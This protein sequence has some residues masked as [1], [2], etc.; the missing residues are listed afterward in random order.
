M[1]FCT[2]RRST[3]SLAL[4]SALGLA[5]CADNAAE[6]DWTGGEGA[7]ILSEPLGTVSFSGGNRL[8][9]EVGFGS[10]ATHRDGD[11]A[12]VFYTVTD[13]GPNVKCSDS[14]DIVGVADFCGAGNGGDKIFPLPDYAPRI[15]KIKLSDDFKPEI[16]ETIELKDADGQP[17]TGLTNPL[18]A[19]DTEKAF[20]PDGAQITFDP[21]GLDTESIAALADGSFWLSDEYGPSLVHVAADGR[22]LQ[23]VVPAS[24]AADL[25]GAGYPVSGALPD[26]LK[27]RK[28]NRGIESVAI[29]PDEN[30]LYFILQ[31][32]LAHPDVAAYAGSRQVRL[33]KYALQADG[34]LGDAL[35]EYVYSLDTPQTFAD[36][37]N[38]TGDL[39]N[40]TLRKQKDVKLSEMVAV[41]TD[42]LIVLERISKVTKL[43]RV[44]LAT[45]DNILHTA[46]SSG[47]VSN[48]ESTS[49][50]TLELLFDPTSAGARPLVKSLAF[51]SLTDLPDGIRL[52]SKVEGIARLDDDYVLLINDNDFGIEGN[53]SVATVLEIGKRLTGDAT[54]SQR[55]QL[56]QRGSY[57]SGI[58][59]QSAAEISAYAEA[60]QEVLVTNAAT[61]RIDIL[62]ASDPAALSKVAELD[63]AT[64]INDPLLG[65][66]NSVAVHG[67]LV[68]AAIERGDGLGNPKQGRGLVAFYDLASRSLLK[69]VEVGHLP[70]ML[71]FTPDGRRLLVA[72]EG[73]PNDA[74]DVDPEGSVSLIAINPQGMPVGMA[75]E[76]GFAEFNS[77]APRAAELPAEVRI[78]G[79]GASVAQDLEPEYIAVAEDSRTAWV[80]L[81]ENNALAEIDLRKARIT[82]IAALGFK[83]HGQAGNAL[84]ASDRDNVDGLDGS[85]LRNARAKINIRNWNHVLGMYQ[86]DSIASYRV[87]GSD[88]VVTANE[89][90]S[91]DYAGFS[92]EARLADV[93][94]AGYTPSADLAAEQAEEALGRL[95][96]TNTLGEANGVWETLYAF[97]AR[98]FSIR[99]AA[100][101]LVFDSGDDFERITAG[102]LGQDFN[103]SNDKAPDDKKNDRSGA[104]G[105][106]PEALVVGEVNGRRYAFIGLERVSG[107]MVYDITAPRGPQFVQYLNHRDFSKDPSVEAAGDVAP[108]G[109]SFVAAADSPSGKPLLI[110]A[111][112]VSGTTTVYEIE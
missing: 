69:T 9:L 51:N 8:D 37:A 53:A 10:G 83:D 62:D 35:G 81:Q 88:Y 63:L 109:M 47:A 68:A 56:V 26:V 27:Q 103:A 4:L 52:P 18:T 45:G 58:Y 29:A 17:I 104:K 105:P 55:I 36:L 94:T 93:I 112:E 61:G 11:P 108:E 74:Y 89:G 5:G 57:A 75:T 100:G 49:D 82:R 28:L 2:F 87:D 22:I 76:I 70:D 20:G 59:D 79:P 21:N 33:M 41:G 72:N 91:R 25:S 12:N 71:T 23:R 111:N 39:K 85:V 86:P 60:T 80:A 66:V 7:A 43:Y 14:A 42:D 24:V 84:D 102:R 19:T 32:P 34:S 54:R 30:Y 1:P 50:K 78:F 99:D 13:R 6:Q 98:S 3:I 90:D 106:E 48:H 77:G 101:N 96:F 92:E 73:E 65:T 38:A 46:V 67:Q 15:Y 110:V 40:G 44:N 95:K 31:S 107:I 64:D 16:L 97:G